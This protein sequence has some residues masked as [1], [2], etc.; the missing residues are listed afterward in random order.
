MSKILPLVRRFLRIVYQFCY[1]VIILDFIFGLFYQPMPKLGWYLILFGSLIISYIF[2]EICS[3]GITILLPH[4][5]MGV[6]YYFI[7]DNIYVKVLMISILV[8][9]FYDAFLYIR[10]NYLLK[11][12]FEAPWPSLVFGII[13]IILGYYVNNDTLK[14]IGYVMPLVIIFVFIVSFYIEGLEDYISRAKRVTGAPMKEIISVNSLIVA[15]I[16]CISVIVIFLGNLLHFD[17]ALLEFL[18][19]L[20][21]VLKLILWV[22]MILFRLL[23][24]FFAGDMSGLSKSKYIPRKETEPGTIAHIIEFIVICL[25]MAVVVFLLLRFF[26]WLIRFLLAKQDRKNEVVENLPE[27]KKISVERERIK[28]EDKLKGNSP[29]ILVRRLYR[30]KVLSFKRIFEPEETFT[31]SD[32]DW[33]MNNSAKIKQAGYMVSVSELEEAEMDRNDTSLSESEVPENG[34]LENEQ[35]ISELTRRY[36]EVRYGSVI[37]D[38]KFLKRVKELMKMH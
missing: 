19:S 28:K 25:V 33:M 15:A 8:V 10:E 31:T 27:K 5:A 13:T 20:K 18:K 30:K 23:L 37:P 2:R 24:G 26:K 22:L 4:V 38:R 9:L 32:L 1:I 6:A 11:R 34:T 21:V 14:V 12:F 7:F 16:V 3:R 36:N 17:K 35:K 29:D